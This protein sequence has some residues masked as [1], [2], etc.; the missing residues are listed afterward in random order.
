MSSTES[1]EAPRPLA[2]ASVGLAS[3]ERRA[4][5]RRYAPV[6]ASVRRGGPPA[7]LD[8]SHPPAVLN[9]QAV[10]DKSHRPPVLD[11]SR[12]LAVL[13]GFRE[14]VLEDGVSLRGQTPTGRGLVGVGS[15]IQVQTESD[16]QETRAG[17]SAVRIGHRP[18]RR[19]PSGPLMGPLRGRSP[20]PLHWGLRVPGRRS[21]RH[22]PGCRCRRFHDARKPLQVSSQWRSVPGFPNRRR[23][24]RPP[25]RAQTYV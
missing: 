15:G 2:F 23:E 24:A 12:E 10:L 13:D 19:R 25:H 11:D 7:V 16:L 4:V 21:F 5:A 9:H 1:A 18:R 17:R 8:Q 6:R 22:P 20:R 14:E 3:G